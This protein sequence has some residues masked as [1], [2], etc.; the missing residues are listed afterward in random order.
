MD[1]IVSQVIQ[2]PNKPAFE[3]VYL[4]LNQL[5]QNMKGMAGFS[6]LDELVDLV[7]MNGVD[8]WFSVFY[9]LMSIDLLLVLLKFPIPLVLF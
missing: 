8:P 2:K 5:I 4:V 9:I 6:N 3:L 7:C 1:W